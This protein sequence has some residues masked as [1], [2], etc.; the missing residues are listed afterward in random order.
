M[1]SNKN[2]K[3][4]SNKNVWFHITNKYIGKKPILNPHNPKDNEHDEGN[5]PRLCVSD[6]I[7]KCLRAVI[8][9]EKL[10]VFDVI[11]DYI[12]YSKNETDIFSSIEKIENKF[13]PY[14]PR[15]IR[16]EF[17][18]CLSI[19]DEIK[20]YG[21]VSLFID[22]NE[23]EML[24]SN[25]KNFINEV[26]KKLLNNVSSITYFNEKEESI[27]YYRFFNPSVYK[28]IGNPY[29]PPNAIDFRLN[30]EHW[31]LQ[32]QQATFSGYLDFSY[33]FVSG[34]VRLTNNKFSYSDSNVL[35]KLEFVKNGEKKAT[36][37]TNTK[38]QIEHVYIKI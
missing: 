7:L 5:I 17:N 25:H 20:K 12:A 15:K 33:L 21:T 16:S 27:T 1:V 38:E 26:N 14:L 34:H 2:K 11:E 6:S 31:F 9:S 13:K 19:E 32:P 35:N 10:E 37:K 4:N 28:I 36:F 24:I 8:G 3:N 18:D 22:Y 30:N 23:Y 29:I